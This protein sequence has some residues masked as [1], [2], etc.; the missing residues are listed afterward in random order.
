MT[1]QFTAPIDDAIVTRIT[2][3]GRIGEVC[4]MLRRPDGRL[5]CAAKAYYPQHIARL[6][7]GGIQPGEDP[8]AALYREIGEETGLQ[9]STHQLLFTITYHG[10]K[11]FI[12]YAYLCDVSADEPQSHDPA[13]QI[14]HFEALTPSQLHQRAAELRAL[15]AISHPDIGGTWQAWGEFRAHCH[16]YGGTLLDDNIATPRQPGGPL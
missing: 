7:T 6:L 3:D 1:P 16:E 8:V 11:P 14:H 9:P 10:V 13:E 5:W 2:R 12:T 4:M 15:P